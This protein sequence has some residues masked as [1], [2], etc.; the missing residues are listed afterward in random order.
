[1]LIALFQSSAHE[2]LRKDLL[3][4]H[5]GDPQFSS[6]L[7]LEPFELL[8]LVIEVEDHV[9][10]LEHLGVV[11]LDIELSGL[12]LLLG[13]GDH[14]SLVWSIDFEENGHFLAVAVFP[15]FGIFQPLVLLICV[16]VVDEMVEDVTRI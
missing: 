15:F 11:L 8:D 2:I 6:S 9:S 16:F 4:E 10:F 14:H 5:F 13:C 12:L 7:H 1:M 3:L